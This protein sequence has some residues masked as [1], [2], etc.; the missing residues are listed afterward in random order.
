MME[1][2][3]HDWNDKHESWKP[4]KYRYCLNCGQKAR[5]FEH[6]IVWLTEDM[7]VDVVLDVAQV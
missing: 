2:T 6:Y 1:C 3:S 5:D 7:E 4:R